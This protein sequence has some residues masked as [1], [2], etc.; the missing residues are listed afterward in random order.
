MCL[1]ADLII[2]NAI[3][4]A[5]DHLQ[6]K[7]DEFLEGYNPELGEM[8]KFQLLVENYTAEVDNNMTTK[9]LSKHVSRLLSCFSESDSEVSIG[10][11]IIL[12]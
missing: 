1:Q 11:S 2:S 10:M 5:R 7:L 8:K 6:D 3:E 9:E 4:N 12:L